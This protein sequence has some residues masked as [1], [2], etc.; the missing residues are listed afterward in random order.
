MNETRFSK[1]RFSIRL[2]VLISL[3]A[4]SSL[5]PGCVAPG[6]RNAMNVAS[7]ARRSGSPVPASKA[8][9]AATASVTAPLIIEVSVG[10]SPA[11]AMA[12]ER[13]GV[14]DKYVEASVRS[15]ERIEGRTLKPKQRAEHETAVRGD[16]TNAVVVEHFD[17]LSE[18]YHGMEA[19]E[20][21]RQALPGARVYLSIGDEVEETQRARDFAAL[22]EPQSPVLSRPG[23]WNPGLSQWVGHYRRIPSATAPAGLA[24]V[25]DINRATDAQMA[26]DAGGTYGRML[27]VLA[28]GRLAG[29]SRPFFVSADCSLSGAESGRPWAKA[30]SLEDAA[31]S[32]KQIK[33]ARKQAKLMP[34]DEPWLAYWFG[35]A[36]SRAEWTDYQISMRARG[37]DMAEASSALRKATLFGVK[38]EQLATNSIAVGQ[39]PFLPYYRAIADEM[40][41]SMQGTDCAGAQEAQLKAWASDYDPRVTVTRDLLTPAA[42]QAGSRERTLATFLNAEIQLRERVTDYLMREHYA[43]GL[44]DVVRGIKHEEEAVASEIK[45]VRGFA[46]AVAIVGVG[47]GMGAAVAG[48]GAASAGNMVAAQTA[49]NTISTIN[50]TVNS[51]IASLSAVEHG[52]TGR[53]REMSSDMAAK[54]GP[55][56]VE[57]AGQTISVTAGSVSELRGKLKELYRARFP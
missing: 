37:A 54:I 9:T 56:E 33:R 3:G 39:S 23:E 1:R 2:A 32:A 19:V 24:F 52:L 55:L 22:K 11:P 21:L 29:Q 27:N 47:T 45:T 7:F 20:A 16:W 31:P 43:G 40:G 25:Q 30:V 12:M 42:L 28:M 35:T 34:Y 18:I 57:L 46:I 50:N 5:A 10:H 6:Q 41:K 38:K 15:R 13:E 4:V 14:L 44:G 51:T 49:Q 53:S 17:R 8:V 48:I 26:L 36:P